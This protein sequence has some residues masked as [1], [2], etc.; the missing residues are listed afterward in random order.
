MSSSG[1]STNSKTVAL[2]G[3]TGVTGLLL[4][5]VLLSRGYRV[6]A[7]TRS[8]GKIP[9]DLSGSERLSVVV[10]ELTDADKLRET[11]VGTDAVVNMLGREYAG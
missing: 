5:R 2:F 10:G 4:L 9:A 1:D 8:P 11:V 7:F 6:R 3:A